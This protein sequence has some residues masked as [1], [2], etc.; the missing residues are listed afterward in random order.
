MEDLVDKNEYLENQMNDQLTRLYIVPGVP[1][2]TK[3]QPKT[4]KEIKVCENVCNSTTLSKRP[5]V[6]PIVPG[7]IIHCVDCGSYW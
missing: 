7:S 5:Q 1:M 3:F 6:S 4:R 2:T